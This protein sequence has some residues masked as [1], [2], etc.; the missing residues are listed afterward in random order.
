[1]GKRLVKE[2][3]G[4]VVVGLPEPNDIHKQHYDFSIYCPFNDLTPSGRKVLSKI[5]AETLEAIFSNKH[6]FLG[7][8][9]ILEINK[10]NNK[11]YTLRIKGLPFDIIEA[12]LRKDATRQKVLASISEGTKKY[13]D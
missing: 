2:V 1:M 6:N 3:D 10:T 11:Y 13:S 8:E 12:I 7:Y 9:L 5:V 4:F